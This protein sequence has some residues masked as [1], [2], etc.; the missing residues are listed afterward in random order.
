MS[1]SGKDNAV[2]LCGLHDISEKAE[3]RKLEANLVRMDR[4]AMKMALPFYES[5][6]KSSR[7]NW[8]LWMP[9]SEMTNTTIPTAFTTWDTG[10]EEGR[11]REII[12]WRAVTKRIAKIKSLHGQLH[13]SS[14]IGFWQLCPV[15][16]DR[17]NALCALASAI[18]NLL[19]KWKIRLCYEKLNSEHLDSL[20]TAN[21]LK[22]DKKKKPT[23]Q[24]W[25]F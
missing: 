6:K 15:E 20:R 2:P 23:N 13:C 3:L 14:L 7:E 25:E 10:E 8:D 21:L 24:T 22:R 16:T 5:L 17:A 1:S 4:A 11:K 9:H 18:Y 19:N 12:W